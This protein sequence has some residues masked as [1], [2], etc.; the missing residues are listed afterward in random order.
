MV[1]DQKSKIISNA[2][3]NCGCLRLG[4]GF[5]FDGWTD[6]FWRTEFSEFKLEQMYLWNRIAKRITTVYSIK[7]LFSIIQ[8][9]SALCCLSSNEISK[10]TSFIP[11]LN[12]QGAATPVSGWCLFD[13]VF[14]PLPLFRISRPKMFII[15]KFDFLTNGQLR[16]FLWFVWVPS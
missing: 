9:T 16:F 4:V 3:Y 2:N 5:D 8:R 6:L 13:S 7:A 1:L 10:W 11:W 15:F 14:R 12:S